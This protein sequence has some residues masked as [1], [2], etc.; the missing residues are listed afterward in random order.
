MFNAHYNKNFILYIIVHFS[1]PPRI[2]FLAPPLN[3]PQPMYIF[4]E[5]LKALASKLLHSQ[6][7]LI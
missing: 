4:L 1:G 3:T 6:S 2:F 5:D 7:F